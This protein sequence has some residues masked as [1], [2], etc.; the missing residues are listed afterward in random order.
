VA[1]KQRPN[2]RF[3]GTATCGLSNAN[4][5]YTLSDGAVLELNV[6]TD[7]DR[8]GAQYGGPVPPDSVIT[9]TSAVVPA[10]VA[11]LRSSHP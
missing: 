3:F 8:T 1:F 10:A 5:A 4:S 6:A 9:D 2:T 7:A 11:W